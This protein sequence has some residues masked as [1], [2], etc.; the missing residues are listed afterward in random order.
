MFSESC[1]TSTVSFIKPFISDLFHFYSN[2][3]EIKGD[4]GTRFKY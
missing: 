3:K 2:V 1:K 4:N